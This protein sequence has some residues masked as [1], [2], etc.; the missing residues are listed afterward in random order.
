MLNRKFL[1]GTTVIAGL[2]AAV[3]VTAPS[4]AFAQTPAP[5]SQPAEEEDEA[6]VEALIITGS[7][8]KRTE[9]TSASPIQVITTENADLQGI[10]DTAEMLQSSTLA[11]GSPQINSTISSAFVTNGGPGAATI[12]LRGLGANRT[13]VLLNGRRA[14]PAGTRGGVSSFDL[15]VLP[16][17][18]IERIEI[19]KDGAS[20]I[21]GSDAIAGVVNIITRSNRDGWDFEAFATQPAESGGEQYR[22]NG[23]WGK[24]FDRGYISI[25][26]DYY[27]QA[28]QT[29]GDRDYTNCTRDYTTN[30]AT[31]ARNDVID[32]R[33]G[34][35]SCREVLWGH[36]WLYDYSGSPLPVGG[37]L[38][39]DYDGDLA[40]YIPRMPAGYPLVPNGDALVAPAEWFLVDYGTAGSVTRGVT[41]TN[42]PFVQS[43]SLIPEV[44][45][46]TLFI[47]G[48]F[49]ITPSVEAYGEFLLN[50][51]TSKTNG[52]RQFWTYLYT[53]DW[54]GAGDPFSAGF[55]GNFWISPTAITDHFDAEQTVDYARAVVG[56]RGDFGGDFLSGWD[57]DVFAQLSR[58]DGDYT[59]DVI[60]DDTMNAAIFRTGSC[61]GTTTPI[62][63][64][65]C[66][67][68]QWLT[69]DF[70]A[71]NLT[72]AERDFLFDTDT[73]N[74][75]Y[76]QKVVE[77]SI[78]GNLFS[79]PAGPVG[80]AFGF[81]Y[82][83]DEIEDTPGPI[84]LANNSWGLSGAGITKG[85]DTTKEL[86]GELQVPIAKGLPGIED[87][88]V[89]LSGRWTDVD[90]YGEDTTYKLGV[91][92][93][94][95][96]SW[97]LRASKGTSFRAP[98]LFELYL[99][100]QTS[101][102]SQRTVDPCIRWAAGLI[103]GT[104][105]QR[106]A[107]N[108]ANPAG[109]GGGVPGAHTGAGG[110]AL[111]IQGGG[112]GTLEAETSEAL[113][114]GLIWSPDFI[115]LNVA[116]DYFEIEV[117]DEVTSLT[118][119]QILSACY[120]S[121]NFPTDPICSLFDRNPG[122]KRIT[123]IRANFLNIASQSNRGIDLTLRYQHEFDFGRFVMDSQFTWQLE[124]EIALFAGANV[125][126]NG[127]VGDP[128]F[129]GNLNFR[130]ERGDWTVNWFVEMIGKASDSED[131]GDTNLAGTI[132]Y[133]MNTEFTAY[134]SASLRRRMD[135][136]TFTG[137]VANLFDEAPPSVTPSQ[138][139]AVG[140]SVLASQYDYYGRRLFLNVKKTF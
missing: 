57:W 72:Q 116:I 82:R 86:F 61:V 35:P 99:A 44:E 136:W 27:L 131:F 17:S 13:L 73:G 10:A 133:K 46:A 75:V 107:D 41:N 128:D 81:H 97:R 95:T 114:V 88:S 87:L 47:N 48:G 12:S 34:E 104:T 23:G 28:E 1:M 65:P 134:H 83:T 112:F 36:L 111:L 37:K 58:S 78:A 42:H 67:D 115:D 120:R 16:Q 49:D 7:R 71:G 38:Q 21:Y 32:P 63:G 109:P 130:F 43:S 106:V 6:E 92:W 91:N 8:I 26:A 9:F 20:S 62:S 22:F 123:E 126:S 138:V 4:I 80:A 121:E 89:S 69:G 59:T 85:D 64:K 14:G 51:R 117:K 24:T 90:S 96:P 124:D 110:S 45:R 102:P 25:S 122:H 55:H 60:L 33:T 52:Y 137:G 132:G 139:S 18:S 94:I 30:T 98:A 127:D 76:T 79:L 108:C 140:T 84:T 105:T 68:I 74:T 39:Y 93:Q 135:T 11:A 77:G 119:G 5:A 103:A 29:V 2:A 40:Q 66:M 101:F 70:M 125:D 50:R 31:R 56:L 54:F 118:G 19:L 129:V 15:N 53:S 100:N 3:A 113:S